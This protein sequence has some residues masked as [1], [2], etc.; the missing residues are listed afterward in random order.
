MENGVGERE[1]NKENG[2]VDERRGRDG[3]GGVEGRG[4]EGGKWNRWKRRQLARDTVEQNE[5]EAGRDM[6]N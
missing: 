6:V 2:G 3:Y 1:S 4:E 5:V